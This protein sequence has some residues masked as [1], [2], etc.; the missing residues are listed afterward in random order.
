VTASPGPT[1]A[2]IGWFELSTDGVQF[3]PALRLI[4]RGAAVLVAVSVLMQLTQASTLDGATVLGS[5]VLLVVA[6]LFVG[7]ARSQ[8]VVSDG[9]RVHNYYRDRTVPLAGARFEVRRWWP[10]SRGVVARPNERPVR[11]AVLWASLGERGAQAVAIAHLN[12]LLE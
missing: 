12:S 7:A 9:I 10:F 1:V 4:Y 6:V 2:R 11:C 3:R 5:I 8:V